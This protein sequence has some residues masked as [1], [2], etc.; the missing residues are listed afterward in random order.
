MLI[1]IKDIHQCEDT[2]AIV[3][4]G[5]RAT[6][7]VRAGDLVPEGTMLMTPGLHPLES[8]PKFVQGPG[9]VTTSPTLLGPVLVWD[10]QNYLRLLLIVRYFG[11]S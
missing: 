9:G 8:G 1:K 10:Q 4:T 6:Y 5:P 3:R 7:V 11:F 2:D